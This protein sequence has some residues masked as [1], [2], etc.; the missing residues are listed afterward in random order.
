MNGIPTELDVATLSID[1]LSAVFRCSGALD[2]ADG[3]DGALDGVALAVFAA[4]AVH[5][6]RAAA[7]SRRLRLPPR[8][9]RLRDIRRHL[10]RLPGQYNKILHYNKMK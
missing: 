3:A 8:R 1:H 9:W 4:A 10:D 6:R 7:T 2:G 5:R